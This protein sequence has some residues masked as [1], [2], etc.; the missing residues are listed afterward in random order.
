[1]SN[2]DSGALEGGGPPD[3]DGDG[4]GNGWDMCADTSDNSY[5]NGK[6]IYPRGCNEEQ[7]LWLSDDNQSIASV[8][9]SGTA[10]PAPPDDDKDGAL[11]HNDSDDNDP[12][13]CS[14]TDE[15]TCEECDNGTQ[16]FMYRVLRK[17]IAG[18]G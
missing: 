7:F 4:V 11:D 5:P 3:D 16:P 2:S 17:W 1:M 13:V 8:A 9:Y 18:G 12:N 6:P 10:P 14:D 15:D